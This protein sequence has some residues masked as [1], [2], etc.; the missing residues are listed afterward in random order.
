MPKG[1]YKTT[2]LPIQLGKHKPTQGYQ[3]GHKMLTVPFNGKERLG[4]KN[5]D[6]QKEQAR[7]GKLGKKVSEETKLKQRLAKL[8]KH[9]SEAQKKAIGLGNKGKVRTKEQRENHPN[10]Q[11]G[12]SFLPYTTDW[13]KSL[14]ISIRERDKYTCQLCGEKQGDRAFCVH[15]IDYDKKNCDPKNLVTLCLKC[16]IK[17]NHKREYWINYFK[18]INKNLK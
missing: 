7:L 1:Y 5:T 9:Q 11:G 17:T 2:G 18:I 13:T 10:Y 8:G 4:C 3:K 12:I 15:H 16:H 6:Y 14:R